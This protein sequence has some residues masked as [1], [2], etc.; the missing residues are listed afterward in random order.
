MIEETPAVVAHG[1]SLSGDEGPV[2]GPLD[3]VIPAGGLTNLTG[4]GGSGRTALALVLSGRMKPSSGELTVLGET[5]RSHIQKRV[6]VAGIEQIDLLERSVTVRDVLNE[7]KSWERPWWKFY[8]RSS[9][10]DLHYY[11]Q[12]VYGERD[13]PPLDSYISQLPALDKLLLR[14]SLALK[15]AHHHEIEMLIMDDLEQVHRFA[16][17]EF[18]LHRLDELSERMTVVVN[19]VNPIDH[20]VTPRTVI[21]LNTNEGH[22]VPAN[23]GHFEEPHHADHDGTEDLGRH[24][25]VPSMASEGKE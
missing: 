22:F 10:G 17:R 5:R 9:E 19:S 12:E 14:V 11:C 2:F 6:A 16:D 23:T 7:N 4:A 24:A 21:E 1:L 15:P 13:L 3:C 20:C 8:S 18:L 25:A